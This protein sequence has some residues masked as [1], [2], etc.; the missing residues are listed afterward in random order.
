TAT[1]APPI[2]TNS[3]VRLFCVWPRCWSMPLPNDAI[4]SN[5]SGGDTRR[6]GA[7][8]S[9][10]DAVAANA[11]IGSCGGV[12][13]S[14]GAGPL[15]D[16]VANALGGDDSRA[17]LVGGCCAGSGFATPAGPASQPFAVDTSDDRSGPG[18]A[19]IGAGAGVTGGATSGMPP[20]LL[21]GRG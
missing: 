1:A 7:D 12:N 3:I 19:T 20:D 10:A 15:D 16:P 18:A 9:R 6:I 14:W 4:G 17:P 2:A 5:S 21:V 8:V 11:A 13:G